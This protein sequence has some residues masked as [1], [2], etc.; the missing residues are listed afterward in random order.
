MNRDYTQAEADRHNEL[1]RKGWEILNEHVLLAARGPGRVGFFARHRLKKAVTLFREALRI[2]PESYPCRWALGKICQALG[3]HERSLGWFE[4]AWSLEKGNADVCREA[5]LA[6]M[7]SG[8]FV[9]ALEFCD[10]AIALKPD[11]A[12]LHCNRALVLMFLEHDA[13]AIEAVACSLRLNATD[14]ATL[15]VR[16]VVHAVA[17]GRRPRPRKVGDL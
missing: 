16:A 10:R 7:H 14:Q 9:K 12:G 13:D 8:D 17:D 15:G 3:D 4:E 11:D 1:I 5:G 6:A 2:A